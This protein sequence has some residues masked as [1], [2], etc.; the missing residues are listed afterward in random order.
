MIRNLLTGLILSVWLSPTAH[1]D[2]QYGIEVEQNELLYMMGQFSKAADLE[3]GR[4]GAGDYARAARHYRK[5]AVLGFPPAQIS[6][7]RLY[8][9][10]QGIPQDYVLAYL[11]Y[12]LAATTGDINALESRNSTAKQHLTQAELLKA[13]ALVRRFREQLP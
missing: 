9:L 12:S 13:Q 11:W 8:E 2:I 3:L 6:L 1:A 5:A 7:G 10:G 4:S